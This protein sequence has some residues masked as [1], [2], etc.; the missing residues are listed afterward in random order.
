M[1]DV[2]VHV[3]V[4]VMNTPSLFPDL[5]PTDPC[6]A[7]AAGPLSAGRRLT[8]RQRAD[9]DAG[10]HPLTRGRLSDDPDARCGNCRYRR[11][12]PYHR[13]SYPK[14]LWG[15]TD[16]DAAEYE[17]DQRPPYVTHGAATDARAWW[18]GCTHHEWG[19]GRLSSD[20]ARWRP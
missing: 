17:H 11:V 1:T 19:D 14:C 15:P 9:V 4:A 3:E 16:V 6:R 2:A 13:R 10:R 12:L 7:D 18:P 20:A 8:I 5:V